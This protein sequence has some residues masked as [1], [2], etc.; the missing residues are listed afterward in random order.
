MKKLYLPILFDDG[1][2][3][4]EKNWGQMLML[5]GVFNAYHTREQAEEQAKVLALTKPNCK[6]IIF[7]STSVVEPRSVEF[8]VKRYSEKGEL[9]V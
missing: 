6:C 2:A 8:S 4:A 9:M 7:E 1:V 3:G 5:D